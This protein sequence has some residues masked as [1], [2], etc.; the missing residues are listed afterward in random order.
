[1]STAKAKA[2]AKRLQESE[3]VDIS[4]SQRVR[5]TFW[6]SFESCCVDEQGRSDEEAIIR[7]EDEFISTLQHDGL[8][9]KLLWADARISSRLLLKLAGGKSL[10]RTEWQQLTRKSQHYW[11][12]IKLLWADVRISSRLLLK[13]VGG[14]SLSGKERQQQ[15]RITADI[16]RLIEHAQVLFTN[17]QFLGTQ[18]ITSCA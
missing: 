8:G 6:S 1:M 2:K 12:G 5:A 14:K 15:T 18:S 17:G 7:W 11:L 9:F 10:S 3:K 13:L 16:S 4:V